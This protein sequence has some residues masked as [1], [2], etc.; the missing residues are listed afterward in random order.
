MW[1][2]RTKISFYLFTSEGHCI[3]YMQHQNFT[4]IVANS[5]M[6]ASYY[7]NINP[8]L[9]LGSF[10]LDKTTRSTIRLASYQKTVL[11]MFSR[12][13]AKKVEFFY[14][15]CVRKVNTES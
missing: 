10:S 11:E 7:Q 4:L 9:N 14:F 8:L 15:F 2:C 3:F 12:S 13:E 1:N 5:F 6:P